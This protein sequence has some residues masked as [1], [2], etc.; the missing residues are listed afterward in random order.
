MPGSVESLGASFRLECSCTEHEEAQGPAY[1]WAVTTQPRLLIRWFGP[2]LE[3]LLTAMGLELQDGAIEL[4]SARIQVERA[5][6]L[7]AGQPRLMVEELAQALDQDADPDPD[8]G[9]RQNLPLDLV[10]IGWATVEFD[11]AARDVGG[12]WRSAHPD[13]LLGASAW[14]SPEDH[15]AK[16]LLDPNTEGRLAGALARYGEGPIALYLGVSDLVRASRDLRARP[17]IGPLGEEWL[18]PGS[19]PDG[20]FLILVEGTSAPDKSNRVPSQP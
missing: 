7:P 18:C 16:L 13:R 5:D 1:P 4:A 10:A 11:R 6:G 17:G 8:P 3:T 12:A 9:R 19:N 20:P 15:P 2:D 14:S